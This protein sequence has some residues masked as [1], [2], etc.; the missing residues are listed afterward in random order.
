MN[1]SFHALSEN[2]RGDGESQDTAPGRMG[3]GGME[4]SQ[5][6]LRQSPGK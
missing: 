2:W 6:D 4:L 1:L 5:G 3:V